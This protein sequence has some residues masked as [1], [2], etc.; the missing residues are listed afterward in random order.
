MS[1][2]WSSTLVR[3]LLAGL[4]FGVAVGA[5]DALFFAGFVRQVGM[6]SFSGALL[7]AG[8][9]TVGLTTLFSLLLAPLLRL[10]R[11]GAVHGLVLS[12][13]WIA[14]SRA[15]AVDPGAIPMWLAAP[16]L[17]ALLYNLGRLPQRRWVAV[18]VGLGVILWGVGLMLPVW[19]ERELEGPP[20]QPR[21]DAAGRPDVLMV[22]I[23]TVR[24]ENM[25][26]Y[27]YDRGTSPNFDMLA[28]EG[29]LWMDAMAPSTWSLPSHASLFT[30]TFPGFHMAHDE[31]RHLG[32]TPPTLAEVLARAGYETRCFTANPH[33]SAHFGLTRGFQHADEVW[34]EAEGGRSMMLVYRIV[35]RLGFGPDDKGGG[36]VVDH[37]TDWVE[38][39][40]AGAPPSFVFINLLEA[41]FPFDQLPEEHIRRYTQLPRSELAEASVLSFGA[42]FGRE[43]TDEEI[44]RLRE[45][46]RDLYDAGIR[47]TDALLGRILEATREGGRLDQTVVLVVSDHGEMVGEHDLYGHGVPMYEPILSVPLLVRYPPRVPAGARATTPVS[48][49]GAYATV[50]DLVGLEPP[51]KP[52][53][54][55]LL[56]TLEGFP[57]GQP[58]LAERYKGPMGNSVDDPMAS[59][60][61]R[62]RVYRSGELK[63]V[64]AT[65]APPLLFDLAADPT[66]AA[67]VA[68]ARPEDLARIQEE[69]RQWEDLLGLPPLDAVIS[70][71]S[72]P[73]MDEETRKQLEA[74]GYVQ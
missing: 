21:A 16:A 49:V 3:G 43:L 5:A 20:M 15:F 2:P 59:L 65:D 66:E 37:Y 9:A 55:S 60:D 44:V 63:L 40:P 53:V 69:L 50:L 8:L 24:A 32:P 12:L 10:P 51:M 23:D 17:A 27:G 46:I 64:T 56:P 33:I 29:A 45:P 52:H 71:E 4:G 18:P 6:P 67:S 61:R 68:D 38:A 1:Q 42:Q 7:K 58:L 13:A 47:Y 30:G 54:G 28:A 11:G 26:A 31:T 48:T 74:L 22:V 39:R 41:H 70:A 73:P 72:A 57:G 25:T 34:R 62:Y 36:R 19:G 14:L 35:D